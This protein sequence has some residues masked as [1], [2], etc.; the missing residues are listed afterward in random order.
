[1][2]NAKASSNAALFSYTCCPSTVGI[3]GSLASGG[4]ACPSLIALKV[5]AAAHTPQDHP[6]SCCL[7]SPIGGFSE[8]IIVG[9]SIFS[10]ETFFIS[11]FPSRYLVLPSAK[12]YPGAWSPIKLSASKEA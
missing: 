1:L 4:L 8:S 3:L 6:S 5:F 10:A 11:P 7:S 12:K 2:P 9:A